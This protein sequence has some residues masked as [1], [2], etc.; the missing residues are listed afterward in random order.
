[1]CIRD[2]TGINQGVTQGC[3]LSPTLFIIYLDDVTRRWQSIYPSTGISLGQ[4]EFVNML[5][6]T[7]DLLLIDTTGNGLQS[8]T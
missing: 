1:M 7:D 2:R 5:L 4:S 6:F 8:A 3:S